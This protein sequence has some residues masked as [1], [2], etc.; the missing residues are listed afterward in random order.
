MKEKIKKS[1]VF[2]LPFVWMVLIFY[3]SSRTR[4]S[5]SGRYWVSFLFFKTLHVIEYGILFLLWRFALYKKSYGVKLAIL[6][7]IFYGITDELH[8]TFV[9][10]REGAVRD[11]LID[12][13]G[14]FIFFRFI[15]NKVED[16]VEKNPFL[17]QFLPEK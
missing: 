3:A 17:K 6:I 15:L 8:Q 1:I 14:I 10:T 12:S 13:F 11:V 7:A 5:V 9:P 4:V 2:I 16:L